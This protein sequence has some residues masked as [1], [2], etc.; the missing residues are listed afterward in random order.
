MSIRKRI[1]YMNIL[2]FFVIFS[3]CKVSFASYALLNNDY[4]LF[5]WVNNCLNT[6]NANSCSKAI[7][8]LELLQIKKISDENYECQTRILALQS[9]MIMTSKAMDKRRQGSRIIEE[10]NYFCFG[11]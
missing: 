9:Y 4:N 11:S 7:S 1:K 3:F 8:G 10:F 5:K 2:F 6:R